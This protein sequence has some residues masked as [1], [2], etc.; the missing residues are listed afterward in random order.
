M[1]VKNARRRGAKPDRLKHSIAYMTPGDEAFAACLLTWRPSAFTL[2]PFACP[3]LRLNGRYGKLSG[4]QRMR[5]TW[6][7]RSAP[8]QIMSQNLNPISTGHRRQ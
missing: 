6:T 7:P 4:G 2:L 1:T 5:T 3:G 8:S